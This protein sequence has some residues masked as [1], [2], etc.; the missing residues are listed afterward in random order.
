[1]AGKG[2]P[3]AKRGKLSSSAKRGKKCNRC[4]V[5]KTYN[6]QLVS[7][8]EKR[9]TDAKDGKTCDSQRTIGFRL[10]PDRLKKISN[11]TLARESMQPLPRA[12][13]RATGA[14]AGKHAAG[15]KR[16]SRSQS[17]LALLAAGAWAQGLLGPTGH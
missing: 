9:T 15:A 5:R 2:A 16:H 13:K 10:V 1:M 12:G 17:R 6:R 14:N 11:Q 4:S 3:D 7:S 8:A